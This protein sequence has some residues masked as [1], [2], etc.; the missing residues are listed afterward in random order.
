MPKPTSW[1]PDIIAL[2]MHKREIEK[3]KWEVIGEEMGRSRTA[4]QAQWDK[5]KFPR[6]QP[7]HKVAERMIANEARMRD[8][9]YR[10]GLEPRDL[11]AA[12][13]GDP[14]PGYSALERRT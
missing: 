12:L 11:S 14:L 13:F 7:N 5:T 3:K 6:Q 4:C 2:L 8:R 1:T 9:D 10:A